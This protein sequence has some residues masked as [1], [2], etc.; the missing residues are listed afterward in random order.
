VT[1]PR[2]KRL[3]AL[4]IGC[5]ALSA[6]ILAQ[7]ASASFHLMKIRE[8]F[9][10]SVAAPNSDFVVLQMTSAGENFV[11][12]H[13]ITLYGATGSFSA[14]VPMT[15]TLGRGDNQ[16]TILLAGSG[17]A[18]AFP[19]GPAADFTNAALS[20]SPAGGAVCYPDG[21][22][23]DCVSWG[24]FTPPMTG[25]PSA[26]GPNASV[27]GITDG[28]ALTRSISAGC[29][30]LLEES[31]DTNSSAADFAESSPTPRAN[32][33]SPGEHACPPPPRPQTRILS[34]PKGKTH[35]RTPT[36]RFSSSLPGGSFRCR[37][38]Q[39]P[40]ARCTSPRTYGRLGF[41]PHRFQVEAVKGGR[42]DLSP[43]TRSF[44]I[45]RPR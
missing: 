31:D 28:K 16:S 21:V 14:T 43:A 13:E 22:P 30:T 24:S 6:A 18:A 25:L 29:A 33:T 41:G 39:K 35:D 8:V 11:N 38:D 7:P 36:F 5:V 4:L 15:K 27:S 19:G 10:G 34:G 26:S 45:P 2:A 17:Y 3:F 1:S 9:P 32:A 40:F 12:G 42:A 44:R 20:L 23:P 37:L